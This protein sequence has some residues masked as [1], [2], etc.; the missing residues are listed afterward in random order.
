[1]ARASATE[2]ASHRQEVK[3][4]PPGI[5]DRRPDGSYRF[6]VKDWFFAMY[7]RENWKKVGAARMWEMLNRDGRGKLYL[8][9]VRAFLPPS[10]FEQLSAACI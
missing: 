1:M 2:T 8:R 4:V 10:E 9:K 3:A 6:R 7:V 5:F